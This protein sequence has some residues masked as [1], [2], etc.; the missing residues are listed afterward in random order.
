M[1]CIPIYPKRHQIDK[2]E[3]VLARPDS[4]FL[5]YYLTSLALTLVEYHVNLNENLILFSKTLNEFS[6][7]Y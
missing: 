7:L 6:D 4:I 3:Y 2:W 1:F 5:E